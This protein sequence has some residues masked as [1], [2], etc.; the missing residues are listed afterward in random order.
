MIPSLWFSADSSIKVSSRVLVC[1]YASVLIYIY[2]FT[3]ELLWLKILLALF[4]NYLL[5]ELILMNFFVFNK[6]IPCLVCSATVL[7]DQ[8]FAMYSNE[9][10]VIDS[11]YILPL[12]I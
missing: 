8:S 7:R 4:N 9:S 10:N 5:L 3:H 1:M 11:F 6:K 2:S 12:V